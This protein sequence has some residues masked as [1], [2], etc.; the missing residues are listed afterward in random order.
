[1]IHSPR[2]LLRVLHLRVWLQRVALR[3]ARRLLS[4]SLLTGAITAMAAAAESA[5]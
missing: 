1:M 2:Q 4:R 3:A 5:S